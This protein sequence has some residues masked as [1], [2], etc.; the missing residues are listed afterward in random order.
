MKVT[1]PEKRPAC[2]RKEAKGPFLLVTFPAAE[3]VAK[4]RTFEYKVRAV[5]ADGKKVLSRRVM[6]PGFNLPEKV[7]A[8]PGECLFEVS[9]FEKGATV[10]FEVRASECF[11][12]KGDP[13]FSEPVKI[14]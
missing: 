3:T 13:I 11:G 14:A 9:E 10:K 5:D 1:F 12:T 2:A 4:C 8:L 7:C 6:A